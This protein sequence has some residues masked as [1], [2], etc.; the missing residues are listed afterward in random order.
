MFKVESRKSSRAL[1][2]GRCELN[3][4]RFVEYVCPQKNL[5]SKLLEA[6]F[7]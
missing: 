3:G 2:Y 7:L 5:P 6:S 1:K 4:P